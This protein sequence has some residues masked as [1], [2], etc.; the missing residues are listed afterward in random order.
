MLYSAGLL[1]EH[2]EFT[3][4]AGK[5]QKPDVRVVD[6]KEV[7]LHAEAVLDRALRTRDMDNERF[8]LKIRRRLDA[9][10]PC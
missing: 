1:P 2:G 9:C 7:P 3:C 10:T 4:V 8:L 6:L 5:G